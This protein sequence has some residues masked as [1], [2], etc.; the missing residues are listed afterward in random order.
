VGW[1][2]AVGSSGSIKAIANV[3]ATLKITDGSINRD[4]MEELRKRLV[5]MG[6]VEKLAELGVR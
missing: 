5:S 4:G 6:K 3:L 2:S 1:Q